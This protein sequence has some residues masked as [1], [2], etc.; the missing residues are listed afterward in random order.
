MKNLLL[1]TTTRGQVERFSA[2]PTHALM[3]VGP[4]G[5]GKQALALRMAET[6]LKLPSGGFTEY[7]YGLQIAP[8]AGKAI[9]IAAVRQLEQFLSLK[10][11]GTKIY[12]RIIIIE[13]AHSMTIEAQNALLKSLEEPPQG[14]ILIL[15]LNHQAAVLPTI[16]S[17][18]QTIL[19]N[20]L[21]RAAVES[22][23]QA[24]N[25]DAKQVAQAYAISGGLPG[26]MRA[27]LYDTD[28]PLL[29]ATEQA[30][31]LLSQSSYERLL[32]IDELVK[33]KALALDTIFIM[34]QMAHVSLQTASGP[35]TKKWHRVL[36]ATYEAAEA[37]H[38][39]GQPKLVL[40]NLMLHL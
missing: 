9:G 13:S 30:R 3:L 29:A 27:L 21:E 35:A 17:R 32:A 33:Q 11:P 34:Q 25:F 5:S 12:N 14:T 18:A 6:I 1:H 28:H 2:R 19:V 31:R 16:R 10:V 40:T 22:H 4:T 24:Q 36:Q 8:E 7:P 15:T 38:N 39:S 20:R 26:L 23:F 37:L